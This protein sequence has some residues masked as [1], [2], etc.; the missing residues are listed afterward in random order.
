MLGVE[1]C[2]WYS[3]RPLN[4][5]VSENEKFPQIQLLITYQSQK[6]CK[7]VKQNNQQKMQKIKQKAEKQRQTAEKQQNKQQTE[8]QNR[9]QIHQEEQTDE[10]LPHQFIGQTKQPDSEF[11]LETVIAPESVNVYE[12]Q[13]QEIH[14]SAQPDSIVE[15]LSVPHVDIP[16]DI[17]ELLDSLGSDNLLISPLV[18]DDELLAASIVAS[19]ATSNDVLETQT[20]HSRPNTTSSARKRNTENDNTSNQNSNNSSRRQSNADQTQLTSV[21]PEQ[22]SGK[23]ELALS[24]EPMSSNPNS[25]CFLH[26]S[27]LEARSLRLTSSGSVPSSY[28]LLE[29][30]DDSGVSLLSPDSATLY[31]T[32]IVESSTSPRFLTEEKLIHKFTI[33]TEIVPKAHTL[34]FSLLHSYNNSQQENQDKHE[35]LGQAKITLS[36]DCQSTGE[37][38]EHWIPI[39]IE[40]PTE[41]VQE[42]EN[43]SLHCRIAYKL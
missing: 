43:P 32:S 41:I 37:L 33:P 5:L 6:W 4:E 31:K 38:T 21:E 40:T 20:H 26:I 14:Q 3:V 24:V 13:Q 42:A 27:L 19:D 17:P 9:N 15:S 1:F 23:A 35:L 36:T 39:D 30:F 16:V 34:L 2:C 12:S 7:A 25:E 11:D 8:S 10:E 29:V 22:Q 18:L 28:C